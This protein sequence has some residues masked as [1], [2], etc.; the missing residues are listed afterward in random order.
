MAPQ[1]EPGRAELADIVDWIRQGKEL[2]HR[3]WLLFL[4]ITVLHI[5]VSVVTRQMG[6]LTMPLGLFITQGFL[7]VLLLA[8]K[9]ADGSEFL[10]IES[11]QIALRRLV[12]YCLFIAAICSVFILIAIVIGSFISPALPARD[13]SDSPVYRNID[14]LAP[15]V[16]RFFFIYAIVTICGVWF[17]YPILAYLPLTLKEAFLLARRADRKNTL[18]LMTVGYTPLFGFVLLLMVSEASLIAGTVFLP[19]FAAVQYVAY[20]QVFMQRRSNSPARSLVRMVASDSLS[21]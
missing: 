11:I 7:I 14:W 10:S 1:L 4:C 12:V 20:R 3:R 6:Y 15:G 13:Y 18:V 16:V 2:V 21:A 17:I 19:Y 9:Q 8:A 5:G